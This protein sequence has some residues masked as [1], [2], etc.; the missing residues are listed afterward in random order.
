MKKRR[1][2]VGDVVR[3]RSGSPLMTVS[4]LKGTMVGSSD[5][6]CQALLDK[7]LTAIDLAHLRPDHPL[8][9][10]HTGVICDY[11]MENAE[12]VCCLLGRAAF[13]PEEL[14]LVRE[15]ATVEAK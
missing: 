3:L 12:G 4:I 11:F 8:L 5:R 14:E 9:T 15:V 7:G 1:F 6:F 10:W 2:Q 13:Q